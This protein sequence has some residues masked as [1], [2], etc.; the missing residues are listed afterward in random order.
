[1]G[2]SE[3]MGREHGAGDGTDLGVGR[4]QYALRIS[5]GGSPS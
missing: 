2:C 3:R 5:T 4:M 1:M